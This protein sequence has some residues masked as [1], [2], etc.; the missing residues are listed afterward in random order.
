M[1]QRSVSEISFNE[2]PA[3]RGMWFDQG[4][5]D[6]V[7]DEVMPE[8]SWLDIDNWLEE[9]DFITRQSAFSCPRCNDTTLATIQEKGSPTTIEICPRCE[10]T[11]LA[12]G[13][14]LNLINSL[15]DDA[16][17][18]TVSEYAQ[19]S[20]QQAKELF[21]RGDIKDSDWQGLKLILAL[22]KQR[23][24]LKHPKVKSLLFG[25]QKSLPI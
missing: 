18:K 3:C 22:L 12:A 23:I 8:M 16:H 7:K 20:L 11:L 4:E 2:C 9:T 5:L 24:I 1:K 6:E 14:F 10:G 21:T 17:G 13:Q 15:L 19:M 25:L